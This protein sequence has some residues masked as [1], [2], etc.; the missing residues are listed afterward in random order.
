MNFAPQNILIL[1]F[2]QIGD[3]I[4][5]LPALAAVREKFPEA[6]ITSMTGTSARAIV[7]MTDLFDEI[8]VVD[9]VA[10]R[11]SNK[12]WSIREI[13]K[14]LV[15]TRRKKFDFVIDLHSLSETNLLGFVA[16]AK[17]RLYARRK[18]RSL[19][20]LS[21]F[22]PKPP[23]DDPELPKS[24]WYL[25]SLR[26]LGID[27]TKRTF[28]LEPEKVL[29]EKVETILNNDHPAGKKLVGINLGAGNPARSWSLEKFSQLAARLSENADIRILIFFGPEERPLEKEIRAAFSEEIA[30]YDKFNLKELAAAFSRLDVLVGNDTGPL[31]LGAITGIPVVYITDPLTFRPPGENIHIARSGKPSEVGLEDVFR[32]VEKL[33]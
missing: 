20:W 24:L 12:F 11:D 19:D 3:V 25:K 18:N 27:E 6:R 5:S 26:P 13:F 30:I 16:G 31:Q 1:N 21:N 22:R 15:Q 32:T 4:L 14:L 28:Q 7:E 23:E 9:R 33:L 10:L 8:V 29:L 17:T 2:G